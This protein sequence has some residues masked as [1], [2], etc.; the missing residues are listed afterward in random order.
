MAGIDSQ[1]SPFA[2]RTRSFTVL[3]GGGGWATCRNCGSTLYPQ[4][5]ESAKVRTIGGARLSVEKFRCA[6]G[7]GREVR[8][9]LE[10]KAA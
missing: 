1:D 10:R 4:R 6:C 7:G 3:K 2:G 5:K 8:R 9:P